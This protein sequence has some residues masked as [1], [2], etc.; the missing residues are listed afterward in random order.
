LQ[1][2]VDRGELSAQL[3]LELSIDLLIAPLVFRML[4]TSGTSD[5]EY[6]DRLAAMV[7][8]ALTA[9]LR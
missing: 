2:A 4:V 6:L 5:D 8:G 1:A 3:D 7:E 9:E